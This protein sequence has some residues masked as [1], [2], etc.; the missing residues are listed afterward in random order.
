MGPGRLLPVW[1]AGIALAAGGVRPGAAAGQL[2]VSP[3][4][5][6]LASDSTG[7][8]TLRVT[9][10]SPRATALRVYTGDYEETEEGRTALLPPGS[11]SP[12]GC[13]GRIRV[14][15]ASAVVDHG[16]VTEV[17][18]RVEGAASACWSV[19]YVEMLPEATGRVRVVR[20]VAVKVVSAPLSSPRAG[21]VVA[22]AARA[23]PD[24]VRVETAFRNRSVRPVRVR[25]SVEV[26]RADGTV[27]ARADLAPFNV[28]PGGARRISRVLPGRLP[29]G[30]YAVVPV[31][32][33]EGAYLAGGEA[34]LEVGP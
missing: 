11:T 2:S 26:R 24:G 25:G 16:G 8:A 4:T 14:S 27:A 33:F 17:R 15:P 12:H 28:L 23:M 34:V 20:R 1:V 13:G 19:V 21:E 32:D 6:L 7:H 31:L 18:V 10:T 3:A 22:V 30:R 9:S 5:V 29:P